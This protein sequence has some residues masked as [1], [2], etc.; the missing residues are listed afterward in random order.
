VSAVMTLW[1]DEK[2]VERA[3]RLKKRV[4]KGEIDN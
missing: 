4:M 1:R 2:A 3:L